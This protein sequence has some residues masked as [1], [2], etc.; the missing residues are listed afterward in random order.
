MA[1][2]VAIAVSAGACQLFT[3]WLGWRITMNPLD[4]RNP[5]AKKKR[6]LYEW[7][8][9]LVGLA[10]IFFTGV[11]AHRVP[12]ERAHFLFEIRPVYTTA[13]GESSWASGE[14]ERRATFL[15]IDKPLAFNV[16][17]TNVGF[18]TAVNVSINKDAVIEANI[19][20]V[21]E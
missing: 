1:W 19:S 2:D 3:S 15:Q 12:R 13:R 16:W 10:G 21:S 4:P 18:G 14:G 6:T 20:G 5:K 11:A 17:F 9:P 7:L 8:F